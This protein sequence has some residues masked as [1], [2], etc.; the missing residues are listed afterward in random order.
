[1]AYA[2][3]GGRRQVPMKLQA[4]FDGAFERLTGAKPL[5]VLGNFVEILALY[6]SC[7]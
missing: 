4:P 1:M 3:A 5:Q 2:S 6:V 7:R